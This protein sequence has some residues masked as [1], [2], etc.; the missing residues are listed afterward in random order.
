[1]GRLA[2]W[3][4]DGTIPAML[5]VPP[6]VS[7]ATLGVAAVA[8]AT[9]FYETLGWRLAPQSVPGLVSHLQTEG[10]R[11]SLVK[12]DDI[13]THAGLAPRPAPPLRGVPPGIAA[14]PRAR[15]TRRCAPS[16]RPAPPWSRR[17]RPPRGAGTWATSPTRTATCGR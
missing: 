12:T 9:E 1:M 3:I 4:M 13:S 16:C 11:L 17:A 8:R 2:A 15:A 6:R 14:P 5:S 10:G 7:Q